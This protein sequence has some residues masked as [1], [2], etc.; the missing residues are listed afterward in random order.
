[1]DEVFSKDSLPEGD[2]K[3]YIKVVPT[4]MLRMPGPFKVWTSESD[5][6]PFVCQ[7]GYL[8]VDARGYPYAIA[9]DE[10]AL[11]YREADD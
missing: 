9:A 4:R 7:D 2:W 6:E 8:A 10:H 5:Q 1:M 11:I 3:N